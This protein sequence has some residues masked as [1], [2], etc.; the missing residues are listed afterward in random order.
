MF[1]SGMSPKGSCRDG[2]SVPGIFSGRGPWTVT[3]SHRAVPRL[4]V[5]L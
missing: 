4:P 3:L 5:I 1:V 2:Q